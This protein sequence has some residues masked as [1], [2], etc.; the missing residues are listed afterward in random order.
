MIATRLARIPRHLKKKSTSATP[1][2]SAICSQGKC[3]HSQQAGLVLGERNIIRHCQ[4]LSK[5]LGTSSFCAFP[6]A[7]IESN[8]FKKHFLSLTQTSFRGHS[9]C[10]H[11]ASALRTAG[12]LTQ[13]QQENQGR[14]GDSM[15]GGGKVQQRSTKYTQVPDPSFLGCTGCT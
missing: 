13:R 8:R 1:G 15:G 5:H 14:K 3:K 9:L 2:K 4:Q 10:L 12:C 6:N 11:N 7:Q